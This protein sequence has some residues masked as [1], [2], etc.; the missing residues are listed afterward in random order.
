MPF[1][2]P[3]MEETRDFLVAMGK[4]LFPF[5]NIGSRRSWHGRKTT[6][7]AGAITQ[8]HAHADSAQRDAH[9]L[10]AG[11]GPPIAAW[12]DAAGVPR[13]GATP[14]HRAAAG[15]VRGTGGTAATSGLQMRH[16]A[17]G[18]IFEIQNSAVIPGA[19]GV[20]GFVDC[21]I[22]ASESSG[23]VGSVTRLDAGETLNF[24]S[25]PPGLQTA[26]VLQL[27]LDQDGFDSEGFGSYRGRVLAAFGQP[28]S[29]GNQSDF[30]KWALASLNTIAAAFDYPNRAGRG[31]TDV[32]V[33]YS[34]SGASRA[35]SVADRA[36]VLAYIQTQAPFQVA[37]PN[38][39]GVAPLRVIATIADPQN[40]EI[41]IEIDGQAA[42]LFDW[43]DSALFT[44]SA[45]QPGGVT[46]KLQFSAALPSSLRAGHRLI[47]VGVAT[48]QD[49]REYTIDSIAGSDSV[50]LVETP[51]VAP[52]ATDKIFSGGPVVTPI[53]SAI[54]AHLDGQI[55]YAGRGLTPLPASTAESQGVSIVNL[56]I[57]A[58][59]I[60]PANPAGKYNNPAGPSW[61]GGIIRA[62]LFSIAKYQQGVRNVTIVTPAS[63]YEATDDAFPNDSQIHYITP[64]AVVV[65]KA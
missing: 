2:I 18:L 55:V 5:A 41:R 9:P 19:P 49:G 56:D 54:V 26:V 52:A 15:R 12:G 6:Y 4:A 13:K 27:A 39:G 38:L 32:A 50:I 22:I 37:G 43:D 64:G 47:L 3:N 60:G 62:S 23:S 14:A 24:L 10:T 36:A 28:T 61:S 33:F 17:S 35:V 21:D 58:Q 51:P 48:A 11:D 46:N 53:R 42:F 57:L 65:R 31:T 1:K 59:G 25:T 63:D 20:D 45:W 7:H 8:L 40:V 34:G 16:E 30:V 44:V 29:G